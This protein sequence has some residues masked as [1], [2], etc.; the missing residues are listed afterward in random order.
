MPSDLSIASLPQHRGRV[1]AQRV[2]LG[3]LLVG[4]AAYALLPWYFPQNLTLLKSMAGIFGGSETASGLLQAV[5]HRKP[6]LWIGLAGVGVMLC[7][8]PSQ[9]DATTGLACSSIASTP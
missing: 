7:C 4:F 1:R 6:W 3:W 2:V 8:E 9:T 5:A